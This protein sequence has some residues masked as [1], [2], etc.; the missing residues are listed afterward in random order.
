MKNSVSCLKLMRIPK[1]IGT[2]WTSSSR[3][4]AGSRNRYGRPPFLILLSRRTERGCGAGPRPRPAP[5]PAGGASRRRLTVTKPP[6]ALHLLLG[7]GQLGLDGRG[8]DRF[9]GRGVREQVLHRGADR[10]FELRLLR[11]LGQRH[12]TGAQDVA[13][14]G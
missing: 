11:Y 3:S 14:H 2:K 10:R 9:P 12:G 4:R 13:Q 7:A 5:E 8:A 1:I 6:L